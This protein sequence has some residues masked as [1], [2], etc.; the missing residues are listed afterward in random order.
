MPSIIVP[1]VIYECDCSPGSRIKIKGARL[2]LHSSRQDIYLVA[3]CRRDFSFRGHPA[4]AHGNRPWDRWRLCGRVP[5]ERMLRRDA[6][7]KNWRQFRFFMSGPALTGFCLTLA[8][9]L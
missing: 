3:I 4:E 2:L 5:R 9:T 7:P 8:V 1:E 6:R